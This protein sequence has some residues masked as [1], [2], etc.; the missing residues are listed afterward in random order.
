MYHC[1]L[2]RHCRHNDDKPSDFAVLHV[3]SNP[4]RWFLL[5]RKMLGLHIQLWCQR[6]TSWKT[7]SAISGTGRWSPAGCVVF[8]PPAAWWSVW[9]Q[10]C[11]FLR[12]PH[13]T[14]QLSRNNWM[15]WLLG[16]FFFAGT[17]DRKNGRR[18]SPVGPTSQ[19]VSPHSPVH[20]KQLGGLK[21]MWPAAGLLSCT[22][23]NVGCMS[24]PVASMMDTFDLDS[25]WIDR[26]C[27]LG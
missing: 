8:S 25:A 4:C 22:W 6:R 5:H 18:R 11:L 19:L 23:R 13:F 3:Q 14:T 20:W 16:A 24:P 9:N 21:K 7:L 10:I 27:K 15:L 12:L 2:I 26:K 1:H 17:W